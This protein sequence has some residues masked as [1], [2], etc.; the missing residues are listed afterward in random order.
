MPTSRE[1]VESA[2]RN[3]GFRPAQVRAGLAALAPGDDRP[4]ADQLKDAL[5]HVDDPEAASKAEPK[6][7]PKPVAKPAPKAEAHPTLDAFLARP[8]REQKK[9]NEK[10]KTKADNAESTKP[11]KLKHLRKEARKLARKQAKIDAR[12]AEV[13]RAIKSDP[14]TVQ[15]GRRLRNM[16][17]GG[18][19]VGLAIFLVGRTTAAAPAPSTPSTGPASSPTPTPPTGTTPAQSGATV[20]VYVKTKGQSANLRATPGGKV[21][22]GIPSGTDA[23]V[24]ES[25]G[26]WRRV[27]VAGREGWMDASLLPG[28]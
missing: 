16:A 27:S 13:R 4:V 26:T 7:V 1:Q 2:L 23:T 10:P 15:A 24:L 21:I 3:L 17:I 19:V 20:K 25:R 8:P 28:A 9:V 6:P 14:A 18:A 12:A 5:R 22:A 11:P